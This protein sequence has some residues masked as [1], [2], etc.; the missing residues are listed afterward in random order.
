[1]R[2]L[3][4]LTRN[5]TLAIPDNFSAAFVRIALV[6]GAPI[7]AGQITCI[8]LIHHNKAACS[9]KTGQP[10]IWSMPRQTRRKKP[11]K[12]PKTLGHLQGEMACC[13]F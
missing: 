9:F 1:M 2:C 11:A 5:P 4:A 6:A 3:A 10:G 13:E 12:P 8:L 7:L